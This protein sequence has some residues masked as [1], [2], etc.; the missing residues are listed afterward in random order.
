MAWELLS[1]V[2]HGVLLV[3]GKWWGDEVEREKQCCGGRRV[4]FMHVLSTV[5]S[6]KQE[7]K[8]ERI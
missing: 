5:K 8:T 6:K 3:L 4:T 1:E 2:K 7:G